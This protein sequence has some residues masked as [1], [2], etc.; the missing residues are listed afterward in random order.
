MKRCA[1]GRT[2]TAES[3]RTLPDRTVYEGEDGSLNESRLCPCQSHITIVLIPPLSVDELRTAVRIIDAMHETF[4]QAYTAQELLRLVRVCWS[5][6][7]DILPDQ[8]TTEQCGAALVD[9]TAPRF[10]E[11]KHG[12][13]ALG[14]SDCSCYGCRETRLKVG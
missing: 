9:G 5:S 8:W 3:W 4:N 12:L 1:C 6:G 2:H 13:H 11:T 14:V 7:W 10:E